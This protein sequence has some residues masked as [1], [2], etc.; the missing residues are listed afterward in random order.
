MAIS[1]DVKSCILKLDGKERVSTTS[2]GGS[3]QTP[4]GSL[5][6]LRVDLRLDAPAMFAVELDLRTDAAV[7][8]LDELSPGMTIEIL[9]GDVGK[10]AAV[11]KGEVHYIEPHFRFEG[12]STVSVGGYDHSHRLTRG[13]RSRTWG[14][15]VESSQQ[16]PSVVKDVIQQAGDS[17]SPDVDSLQTRVTYVPQLNVSDYQMLQWLAQHGGKDVQADT[18]NDD[19]KIRFKSPD[20]SADPILTLVRESPRG[21]GEEAVRE[22]RFSMSTVRQVAAVEVRGWDA[23]NKKA[24]VG[25]AKSTSREFGGEPG[26][27]VAGKA[28]YGSTSK[29]KVL[30]IVDHPVESQ[31]EAEVVAQALFDRLSM[32]FLTGEVDFPG[33]PKMQPGVQV[34]MRGFGQHFDGKYLVTECAHE[35]IPKASGYVTR[36]K[37]ARNDSL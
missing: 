24:I 11:F 36:I 35:M 37:I 30:T 10:E 23:L 28:L 4:L 3:T 13:T 26:H 29:G 5:E 17:L 6:S 19:K 14:N 7:T 34:K 33:N 9:L 22:A 20:L 2:G 16:F 31:Q 15:G 32:D 1:G 12:V 21:D 27:E 25:V 8:I 18:P